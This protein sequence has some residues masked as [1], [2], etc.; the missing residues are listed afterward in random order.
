MGRT[1]RCRV[2]Q[3][4]PPS[5]SPPGTTCPRTTRSRSASERLRVVDRYR[6][7][8]GRTG[9]PHSRTAAIA[10]SNK[11]SIVLLNL[12]FRLSEICSPQDRCS[13]PD[14]NIGALHS[15]ELVCHR[16]A[17]AAEMA[18]QTGRIWPKRSIAGWRQGQE[19]S[20][21]TRPS[22]WRAVILD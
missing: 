14:R 10:F 8:R 22:P 5:C 3:C 21:R 20:C 4:R 13:A 2:V 6:S 7:L 18:S 17:P 16:R 15:R 9:R 12:F 11:T 19:M 1:R